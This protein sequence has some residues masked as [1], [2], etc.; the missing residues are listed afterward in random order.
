MSEVH[1]SLHNELNYLGAVDGLLKNHVTHSPGGDDRMVSLGFQ[2]SFDLQKSF[3]SVTCMG[4]DHEEIAKKATDTVKQNRKALEELVALAKD[5]P[6]SQMLSCALKHQTVG[7][8]H[9]MLRDSYL[10]INV[11]A[12]ATELL[13]ELPIVL[14]EFGIIALILADQLERKAQFLVF[15]SAIVWTRSILAENA[16]DLLQKQIYPPALVSISGR[17]KLA[18]LKSGDVFV[19]DWTTGL[20][21]KAS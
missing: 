14:A 4:L 7:N 1:P 5:C 3:P 10:D 15:Q 21:A 2:S 11:Q 16:Q 6:S 9:L 8:V 20:L 12:N 18:A 19:R 17:K 13:T